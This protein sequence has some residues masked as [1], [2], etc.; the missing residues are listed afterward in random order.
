MKLVKRTLSILVTLTMI[1]SCF[2]HLAYAATASDSLLAEKAP[3]W[4]FNDDF[5]SYENGLM[6][7]T[8]VISTYSQKGNYMGIEP[9]PS[10]RD[11]SI[12]MQVKSKDDFLLHTKSFT[13]GLAGKFVFEMDIR[14]DN[15]D[16]CVKNFIVYPAADATTSATS[17]WTL[18]AIN[19]NNQVFVNGANS[20][21]V[22]SEGKFTTLSFALDFD[23]QVV[24]LYVNSKLRAS[25]IKLS[26]LA[27]NWGFMRIHITGVAEGCKT[28]AYFDNMKMYEGT[29]ALNSEQ[30][31][32]IDW[33]LGDNVSSGLM[34][35][36][37]ANK[38]GF[39][40]DSPNCYVDGKI[41]KMD[42]L[43]N[44]TAIER[45][46]ITYIPV[47]YGADAFGGK[48]SWD[49]KT[50]I[51]T[52]T[53]GE[54]RVE[55]ATSTGE[56]TIDGKKHDSTDDAF[57]ESG[58]TYV[59]S[60][61]F[62]ELSGKNLWEETGIILFSEIAVDYN[63]YDD[64]AIIKELIASLC[65]E[66]P[67]GERVEKE[68]RANY[69]VG[70]HPRIWANEADFNRIK[71]EVA[72]SE[73]K[74]DWFKRIK[75][76]TDTYIMDME[77]PEYGTTDGIRMRVHCERLFEVV[78][79]S[80]F[81]W[82][83]TGE[84]KYAQYAWEWLEKMS[85]GSYADWNHNRHWL[86]T[87]CFMKGFG[88]GY[89]WLYDWMNEEQ[90]KLIRDTIVKFGLEPF[91]DS[92]WYLTTANDNWNS[93]IAGGVICSSLAI[94]DE[95]PEIAKQC[96]AVGI[97]NLENT[98]LYAAPDGACYEG[99]SYWQLTTESMVEAMT[100]LESATG[101]SYGLAA[102]PGIAE[103]GYFLFALSGKQTLNYGDAGAIDPVSLD[104]KELFWLADNANDIPLR[105]LRY[106]TM[107][108]NNIRP[109]F[110]EMIM[111]VG[112]PETQT[113]ELGL[114]K[115][116][117]IIETASMRNNW[118]PDGMLWAG[119]HAGQTL[120]NHSHLDT[121]NFYID[122]F[123]DRFAS[124]LGI[125]NYNLPGNSNS[126]Y[127]FRAEGHNLMVF[128]PND[129]GGDIL[130]GFAKIER[131]ENNEVSSII[132]TDI[133]CNY[134]NYVESAIRGMRFINGRTSILLQDEV[135]SERENEVYWF[136]HTEAD[137]TL[138]ENGKSAILDIKGNKLEA[139]I[140][141]DVGTFGV[142]DAKPL[143][144]SPKLTGQNEN[145]GSRKL[146]IHLENAKD[147][148]ISVCFTPLVYTPVGGKIKYPAVTPIDTWEL[149]DP[150]KVSIGVLPELDSIKLDG[151]EIPGFLPGR[152]FYV[153][154]LKKQDSPMPVIEASGNG[155]V[156]I[157]YPDVWPGNVEI[158]ISNG[159]YENVYGIRFNVPPQS[160]SDLGY[161]ELDIAEVTASAVPQKENSPENAFDNDFETRF[162]TQQPG[163]ICIDLGEIKPV[164]YVSLA[165][166]LGDTRM[167]EFQIEV[168][169]DGAAWTKAWQGRDTGITTELQNFDVAGV[170]ARYIRITGTGIVNPGTDTATQGWFSPTELKVYTK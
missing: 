92:T 5:N 148:T 24:S 8:S 153:Q 127:R 9:V 57:L 128:N 65:Y 144:T 28:E 119:L 79:Y 162:S 73:I 50:G 145:K 33:S 124:D 109:H 17:P 10:N 60:R 165:F 32:Q 84:E 27:K 7:P 35:V 38:L 82:Q 97:K 52:L 80:A 62:S 78:G 89:D 105:N 101:T 90:R 170:S 103:T 130:D 123:G 137:V 29:E 44:V 70:E 51:T 12:K 83:M 15:P 156:E 164:H 16:A 152:N 107:V 76:H 157:V 106:K 85:I 143:P 77:F 155:N 142:M 66:R 131:F 23:K 160:L 45:N 39:F 46:S 55:I 158:K 68:L 118:N 100:A 61:L 6:P 133:T 1:T 166:Y 96:V 129:V 116:Y 69:A 121:G 37:M 53:L 75:E 150:D 63:W 151:K 56:I 20:G 48:V 67:D 114:D 41:Q 167:N 125:E 108:E 11:K 126:K 25:N 169:D 161:T 113:N 3:K 93:V 64:E 110:R 146:F 112:D 43:G 122:S 111:C 115:Y 99:P 120:A 135:K 168:S 132:T 104:T 47:K 139:K 22:L 40:V 102:S 30:I 149:E 72:T 91:V 88:I 163:W 19:A 98:V 14:I 59:S 26:D 154:G 49:D 31:S 86:D 34:E 140:L 147:F 141:S 4:I 36:Y 117:R 21:V 134:S 81:M 94:M 159:V 42:G 58:R 18:F 138:S 74:R 71:Q 54:K 13:P 95:E 87:G 2:S 136:M